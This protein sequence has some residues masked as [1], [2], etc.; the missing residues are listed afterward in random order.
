MQTDLLQLLRGTRLRRTMKQY[1]FVYEEMSLIQRQ[2]RYNMECKICAYI[3]QV[4]EIS[5]VGFR[6]QEILAY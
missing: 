5:S 6:R 3:V 4:I 2:Q 1:C